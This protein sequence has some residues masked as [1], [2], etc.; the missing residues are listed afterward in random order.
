VPVSKTYPARAL[1]QTKMR[2][3]TG[4]WSILRPLVYAALGR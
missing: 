2:P 4:W 1:G 3:L